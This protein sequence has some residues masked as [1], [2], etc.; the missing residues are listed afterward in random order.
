VIQSCERE[1]EQRPE[2]V[3]SE[4]GGTV[5]DWVQALIWPILIAVG[6]FWLFRSEA[7]ALFRGFGGLFDRSRV[8]QVEIRG[9]KFELEQ[10]AEVLQENLEETREE[11]EKAED[12][13]DRQRSAEKLQRE[14]T[15]LGAWAAV[16]RRARS[17]ESPVAVSFDGIPVML[18]AHLERDDRVI[19]Y[20]Q[21]VLEA[22]KAAHAPKS[23]QRRTSKWPG[24]CSASV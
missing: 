10:V 12:P 20:L 13:Q 15:A 4:G 18:P 3:A 24:G 21:E 1:R 22:A 8:K 7:R 6:V 14:A 16:A 23:A 2:G 5:L 11:L 9:V 17:S 19:D